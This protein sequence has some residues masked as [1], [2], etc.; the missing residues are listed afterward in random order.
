MIKRY[1]IG[2]IYF[3]VVI[4]SLLL[5]VASALDIYSALG[6]EDRD[7]FYT[8]VVQLLIFGVL[9]ISLY[10]LTVKQDKKLLTF[11]QDFGIRK[12]S[13]KNCL[14]V[15]LIAICMIV[16]S[17]GVS[18]VWQT[19]L[20]LMGFTRVPSSTDYNG[21]GAL[22]KQL[23]LIAVLPA[24]F[25]ELSHRGL[26][27]AGYR[28]C[29][30]KFVMISAIYFSLMHQNI[31][32]TGYTFFAG[33]VMALSMYYTGSIFPGI[34][35]HFLNNAVSVISGYTEQN[36]GIFS[37][38]TAI[39]DWLY[40]TVAGFAVGCVA[41]L[42]S[43]GLLVFMFIRMRGEAQKTGIIEGDWFEKKEG[44]LPLFSASPVSGEKCPIP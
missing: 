16:V 19:V 10:F 12:V 20:S 33:V 2:F 5:R 1:K 18:Y 34:F 36:G 29:G 37:F 43:V 23:V 28:K 31:V 17:H 30:W 6:V 40:G 32:Q 21:I 27:Y 14:R 38:V 8:C 35:M 15:L 22:F 13:K 11:R 3:A 9:P 25:E 41:V 26:I 42:I 39:E 7:A 44:V 4:A 24:L